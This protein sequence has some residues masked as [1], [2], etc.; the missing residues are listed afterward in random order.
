MDLIHHCHSLFLFPFLDF[1]LLFL[2]ATGSSPFI[3]SF[4]EE[5][6]KPDFDEYGVQRENTKLDNFLKKDSNQ[7]ISY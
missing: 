2:Y 6:D 1:I 5:M 3:N 7:Y 4:F